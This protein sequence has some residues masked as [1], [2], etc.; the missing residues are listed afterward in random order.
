MATGSRD[1]PEFSPEWAV[2]L[3]VDGTL[4]DITDRPSETRVEPDLRRHLEDLLEITG[5]AM[6]LISGRSV[7]D[8]D[9]LFDLPR[10]C[11]AGQHGAERRDAAGKLHR[12]RLPDPKL[13]KAA[14]ELR[15]MVG[16]HPGLILEEK[17]MSLALHFR[18]A[19]DAGPRVRRVMRGLLED[20]G[21]GF[22]MQEGKMVLEI[23]P[24]GRDKGTAIGAFM[25]EKPFRAR[26]PVFVGDDLT[27]EAGFEFVNRAGGYS[28]KVGAGPSV[29][30]LRL[31]DAGAVRAWLG[32][33]VGR[34]RSRHGGSSG[35]VPL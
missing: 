21:E 3:D 35:S 2:F 17:S 16:Q 34:R 27:D 7:A 15:R 9:R 18:L 8:I 31:P 32:A 10:V 23:K 20:L 25:E 26:A 30:R 1:L 33:I 5:G 14:S 6:A 13:R 28:V 24:G 4:L 12:A 29:A 19:A 22:E 11:V